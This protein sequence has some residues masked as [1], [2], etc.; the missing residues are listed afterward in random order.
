MAKY[1]K[2]WVALV[3]VVLLGGKEFFGLDFGIT[4][5]QVYTILVSLGTAFGVYG[6]SNDA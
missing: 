5:D 4:A 1:A 3:G 6:V 2:F